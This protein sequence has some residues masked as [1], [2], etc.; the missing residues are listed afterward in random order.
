[1]TAVTSVLVGAAFAARDEPA[2]APLSA[3]DELAQD[4][5]QQVVDDVQ[6]YVQTGS[7]PEELGPDGA[8]ATPLRVNDIRD[9]LQEPPATYWKGRSKES[10]RVLSS[11]VSTA[12]G[13]IPPV[14]AAFVLAVYLL[15]Q[16]TS[17]VN[18]SDWGRTCLRLHVAAWGLRRSATAGGVR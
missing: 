5:V 1:L 6:N 3:A 16:D 17:F 13:S 4:A 10:W 12:G 15:S 9:W 11:D 8:A 2:T 7:I 14:E 18:S